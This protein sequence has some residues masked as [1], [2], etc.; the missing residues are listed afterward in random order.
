[1]IHVTYTISKDTVSL[2]LTGHACSAK[3]GHDLVCASA[4]ILCYTLASAL[5]SKYECEEL[6]NKPSITLSEGYA[7]IECIPHPQER[8]DILGAY[9]LTVQGF[10]LLSLRYPQYVELIKNVVSPERA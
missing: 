6:A 8:R 2:E 7:R 10:E 4:S 5:E 9:E 3:Y 1:M